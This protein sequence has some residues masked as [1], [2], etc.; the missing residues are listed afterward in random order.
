[1]D[2]KVCV[3]SP[4][5]DTRLPADA[6]IWHK[7][8]VFTRRSSSTDLSGESVYKVFAG[9]KCSPAA[10]AAQGGF[11]GLYQRVQ[12]LAEQAIGDKRWPDATRPIVK[13]LC[14]G[15]RRVEEANVSV[16]FTAL[17]LRCSVGHNQDTLEW[18]PT[19]E[20][21]V[22]PGGSPPEELARFSPQHADELY[23]EFD[24]T[25]SSVHEGDFVTMSYGER[26]PIVSSI[27]FAP[28]VRRAEREAER[29]HRFLGDLREIQCDSF[30]I[31]HREWFLAN[32]DF[33]TVHIC[34]ER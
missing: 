12:A 16:A 13:T 3:E 20:D 15:W 23:N 22:K 19:D 24:F 2:Q 18:H 31:V 4:G 8:M 11:K 33:V 26:I 27:D 14:N 1:M 34:F 17:E 5:R 25:E 9:C 7:G 32:S 21:F 28:F 10:S 6:N 29:Y 30:R